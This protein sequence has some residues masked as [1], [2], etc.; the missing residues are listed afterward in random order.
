MLCYVMWVQRDEA[1]YIFLF[2]R[3]VSQQNDHIILKNLDHMSEVANN[4]PTIPHTLL[5]YDEEMKQL[6]VGKYFEGHIKV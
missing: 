2:Q 5:F 6:I 4:R 3:L 1:D